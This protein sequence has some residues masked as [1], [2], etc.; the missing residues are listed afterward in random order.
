MTSASLVSVRK[1][2]MKRTPMAQ[3]KKRK[4]V[5]WKRKVRARI[6]PKGT[7]LGFARDKA[8]KVGVRDE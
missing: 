7:S 6:A 8:R 4:P 2:N 5:S 3:K 1:F